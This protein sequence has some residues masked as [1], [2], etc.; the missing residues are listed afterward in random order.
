VCDVAEQFPTPVICALLGTPPDDWRLF[1]EWVTDIK[2]VFDRNLAADEACILNAWQALDDYLDRAA[3]L[4]RS[5]AHVRTP[6][7]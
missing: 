6:P 1:S 2:K 4:R 7:G 3:E 5:G